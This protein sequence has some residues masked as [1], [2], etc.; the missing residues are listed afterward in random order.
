MYCMCNVLCCHIFVCFFYYIY[1]KNLTSVFLADPSREIGLYL[2]LWLEMSRSRGVPSWQVVK[3][4]HS[5]VWALDVTITFA[6]LIGASR[7][8]GAS[9]LS[10]LCIINSL[11]YLRIRTYWWLL[12]DNINSSYR[13]QHVR[14]TILIRMRR[15]L[16]NIQWESYDWT[17]K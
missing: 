4:P 13:K 14:T 10:L 16:K 8:F 15:M 1:V 3:S 9:W 5:V 11:S 6:Y 7:H 17:E 12:F 2:I